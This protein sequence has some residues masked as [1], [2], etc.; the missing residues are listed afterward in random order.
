MLRAGPKEDPLDFRSRGGG[1]QAVADKSRH[2]PGQEKNGNTGPQQK[3][4]NQNAKPSQ[5]A[6]RTK[7]KLQAGQKLDKNSTA[8]GTD[9]SKQ[10]NSAGA[11]Q[12]KDAKAQIQQLKQNIKQEKQP[13]QDAGPS[14]ERVAAGAAVGN[15]AFTTGGAM[16][17]VDMGMLAAGGAMIDAWRFVSSL[18]KDQSEDYEVNPQPA[19]RSSLTDMPGI[20]KLADDI[21]ANEAEIE[22]KTLE[23]QEAEIAGIEAQYT[24]NTEHHE[25]REEYGV[26]H[27]EVEAPAGTNVEDLNKVVEKPDQFDID[28]VG[29]NLRDVQLKYNYDRQPQTASHELHLAVREHGDAV[30]RVRQPAR[31]DYELPPPELAKLDK[32]ADQVMSLG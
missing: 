15:P 28:Y 6:S 26:D 27:H 4:T 19:P 16:L 3:Q 12:A 31:D 10:T 25:W 22:I 1:K 23:F 7:D 20:D 30:M 14:P 9:A 29:M 11:Q 24:D 17:G 2:Q 32:Y 18:S 21:D 13:Q 5:E 8:K